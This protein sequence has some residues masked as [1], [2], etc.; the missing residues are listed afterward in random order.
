M[1]KIILAAT[2]VLTAIFLVGCTRTSTQT[3]TSGGKPWID[4]A[5]QANVKKTKKPAPQDDFHLHVNH[6]W[7]LKAKIPEGEPRYGS[8]SEAAK[9][10]DDK[11]LS[12]L[13]DNTVPGND[14][15]QV[16]ALYHAFLDWDAR[17]AAGT[18]P[19]LPIIQD[20]RAIKT[21]DDLSDFI[22]DPNGVSGHQR[23]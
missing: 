18:T 23:L 4:S 14:A 3:D 20:I 6:D 5:I 9:E 13:N 7:L 2:T 11:V 10:I 21:I 16:H 12:I 19:V 8:F 22:C 17:N 1:K 15:E